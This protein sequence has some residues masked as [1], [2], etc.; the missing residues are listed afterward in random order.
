VFRIAL[1]RITTGKRR[2]VGTVL[3]VLLGV[4]FLAGT[5]ALSD[6]LRSNF[7]DLFA[8]ANS[9]I[10]V[11]VRG[12]DELKANGDAGPGL[13]QR[14]L[15]DASV[16]RQVAAVPGVADAVADISGYGQILG[17]NG[18]AIG[19]NGPPRLAGVWI[20]DP[21]L[22][23]YRL[24]AGRAPQTA[25][26]VVIN[27]GAAKAGHLKAGDSTI[28]ET[29]E[30]VR[31]TIVGIATFGTAD[32]FGPS[33]FVAFT[34][35]G[36]AAH[37]TKDPAKISRVLVK[38]QPGVSQA[39]L[40]ARVQAAVP[41]SARAETITGAQ[42]TKE[43]IDDVTSGFLAALSAFLLIF[44]GI[45]LLVGTFSIYNSFS[46]LTAQRTRE[47]ALLRT[48]G[49]RRRQIIGAVL[50]ETVAVGV[51]ASL[52]GLA[53][54]L[55]L[56]GLLKGLFDRAGFA[57]PAA[58]LSVSATS[59][60][61]AFVAGVATTVLAGL[62]PAVRASRVKPLAA[63]RDV[64]VDH[65]G[66]SR[67]RAVAGAVLAALGV[68][69]VVAGVTGGGGLGPVGLGAVVTLA[70]L[71]V[72]GPVVAGPAVAV[73]GW[74]AARFRGVT[75]AMARE[76]AR[77]NPRRTAGSATAL[78]VGVGVVVV[79]TVFAS[80]LRASMAASVDQ[81]FGGDL[82]I[83]APSFGAGGL[84]PQLASTVA[85]L[86]QVA[87]AAGLG[88]GVALI[89]GTAEAV[90]VA[91]VPVLSHLLRLDV[92]A[93]SVDGLGDGQLAVSSA[94]A[95]KQGWHV[96]TVV[97][98]GFADGTSRDLTVGAV[99]RSTDL[100]GDY[101][102]PRATWSP[103]A[104]QD[105]D[106]L[107][108]VSLRPGVGLAD[109]EAAVT[110]A[111]VPFGRPAVQDR[112]GYVAA[113]TQRI[114]MM[115]GIVYVLLA[116]SILIALMGIANTLALSVHERTREIGLL[117]AV[118]Q[119]RG[120]VRAML[121]QEAVIVALFGT[122]GGVGLGVFLGWALVSAAGTDV[123]RLTI[124]VGRL[125]AVVV[126]GA[127]AGV[128]AGVRPARRAARLDVLNAVAADAG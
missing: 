12:A 68:A 33:T 60:V 106:R 59:L 52:A 58:G 78:L 123:A 31:V 6:T 99:Y 76:N 82:T 2:L 115:L 73:L 104:P 63:L 15:L 84:S 113:A 4:S 89:G 98:V 127:V 118:G 119:S 32:G 124:P 61:V 9:R 93:G 45:A 17:A 116:L 91:D 19:G 90:S 55:G 108:F 42:L 3:A 125:V 100:A 38:A 7:A 51:I 5:L 77:R 94:V 26:E 87:E 75:G 65:S 36:A 1:R 112:A 86:P 126:A 34:P 22:N 128:L 29:P 25:D 18:K 13:T 57:L 114:D 64:A 70:G 62:A 69:A 43:N 24:V 39:T 74:P 14:G 27:R 23:A 50:A 35:D 88:K 122:L 30:P 103:H 66:T 105:T 72:L 37:L 67:A 71:V 120:Q 40:A 54:G 97:P 95:G 41:A 16:V 85:A 83:S 8:A 117:R 110:R 47:A 20:T 107:V 79:F 109:G 81:S 80:S 111:A 44:A 101:L 53:G 48:L 56:A 92:A 21:D 102:L 121:R 96:G 46:I 49:A 10:D 28:V 11:V